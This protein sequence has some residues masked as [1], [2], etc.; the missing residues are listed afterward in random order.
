[1]SAGAPVNAQ[2]VPIAEIACTPGANAALLHV[3]S[4]GTLQGRCASRMALEPDPWVH[5]QL[6]AG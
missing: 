2:L 5:Y 3:V 6:G 4:A 1:M